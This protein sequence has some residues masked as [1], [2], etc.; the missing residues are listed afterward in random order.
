MTSR[1]I[2]EKVLE[3]GCTLERSI[4]KDVLEKSCELVES[5]TATP[6]GRPDD[7]ELESKTATPAGLPDEFKTA[8]PAGLPDEFKTATPAEIKIEQDIQLALE[9]NKCPCIVKKGIDQ[10]VCFRK[11]KENGRCGF[12]K[13]TCNT[14]EQDKCPCIVV[15]KTKE[16]RICGNKIKANGRCGIH[17]K[18]CRLPGEEGRR[19]V[20]VPESPEEEKITDI[21]IVEPPAPAPGKCPCILTSKKNPGKAPRICGNKIKAN[22][23][24]GIHQKKCELPVI[25]E[26]VIEEEKEVDIFEDIESVTPRSWNTLPIAG[27]KQVL[28]Y[29]GNL[30]DRPAFDLSKYKEIDD[31]I[32]ACLS[33]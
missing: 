20:V 33:L 7:A 24:C 29:L 12:H 14:L 28:E 22:G 23:R 8:T 18:T 19:K 17:Q 16:R 11:V 30:K 25:P 10:R 27:E 21:K 13:T 15:T 2:H 3:Q 4:H 26:A 1:N 5:K 6:A 9:Q 32:S 31:L